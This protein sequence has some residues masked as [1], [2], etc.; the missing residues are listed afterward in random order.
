MI[1][2]SDFLLKYCITEEAFSKTNLTWDEL[3]FIYQDYSKKIH[4][5]E[6]IAKFIAD[7]FRSNDKVHSVR[8]RVKDPEHLIEKIIRKRIKNPAA[9]PDLKN[10]E[11]DITDL[12]GI[13]AIHLFKEDWESIHDFIL[14]NWS[15]ISAR[16]EANVRAG[17]SD[18][19]LQKFIDKGCKILIHPYGYRSIHYLIKSDILDIP[20]TVEIQVR[21][22][23][24]EAWSEIDHKIRYPYQSNNKVISNYLEIF[25]RLAGSSDEM[26]SFIQFLNGHLK[27]IENNYAR[28][29][30]EKNLLILDL[31]NKIE[32]LEIE[33]EQK[34]ELEKSLSILDNTV[35][36]TWETYDSYYNM[37]IS[38]TLNM[39]FD[40]LKS[41]DS[42]ELGAKI[43]DAFKTINTINREDFQKFIMKS[44]NG[45]PSN[46]NSKTEDNK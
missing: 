15:P 30:N 27:T 12:I 4:N 39:A 23:F 8:F 37:D 20:R 11:N 35:G 9:L 38:E 31:K 28:E 34:L 29:I 6:L 1:S 42:N 33:K 17:D 45:L 2:K 14:S 41:I 10:Y 21:T 46:G 24:E 16:P 43:S 32:K 36:K 25:N 13:R 44:L 3:V 18:H 26:G 5:F 22:I 40:T 7:A 19:F